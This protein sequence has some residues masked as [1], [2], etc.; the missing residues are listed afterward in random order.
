MI[1]TKE[2]KLMGGIILLTVP[3][4]AYGGTF[5]LTVLSGQFEMP[6]TDF[7]KSMFRAGHAHAGVLVILSLITL[8]YIDQAAWSD[9]TKWMIRSGFPASAI[10][11]SGGFFAAAIG[12][13]LTRPNQMIWILWTGFGVFIISLLSLGIGLIRSFRNEIK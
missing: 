7:Q 12:D 4:I 8:L 6:L 13:Q 1:M 11:I 10:L 5:L 9:K 2:A 3:T